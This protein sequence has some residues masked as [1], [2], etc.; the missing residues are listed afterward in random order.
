M[1]ETLQELVVGENDPVMEIKATVGSGGTPDIGTENPQGDP[2]GGDAGSQ[3][4][5]AWGS[6]P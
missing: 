4:Y 6:D 2:E 3:G 1:V 5:P